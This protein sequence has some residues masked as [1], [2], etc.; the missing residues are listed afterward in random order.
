MKT[1]CG[2]CRAAM[3][4]TFQ[5]SDHYYFLHIH[6]NSSSFVISRRGSSSSFAIVVQSDN[7]SAQFSFGDN[8][9]GECHQFEVYRQ[10]GYGEKPRLLLSGDCAGL[11]VARFERPGVNLLKSQDPWPARDGKAANLRRINWLFVEVRAQV[12]WTDNRPSS[13]WTRRQLSASSKTIRT[14]E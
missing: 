11:V 5:T 3:K 6:A 13:V 9:V 1:M 7:G 8:S 12:S 14:S 10:G 4:E 2:R